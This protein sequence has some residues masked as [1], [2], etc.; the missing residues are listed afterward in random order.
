M[1]IIAVHA[2]RQTVWRFRQRYPGRVLCEVVKEVCEAG[3]DVGETLDGEVLRP[4]GGGERD[5]QVRHCQHRSEGGVDLELAGDRQHHGID[6]RATESPHQV[7]DRGA[8]RRRLE[9]SMPSMAKHTAESPVVAAS[10][11]PPSNKAGIT[12]NGIAMHIVQH[13]RRGGA[14]LYRFS[15]PRAIFSR[16]TQQPTDCMPKKKQSNTSPASASS[17]IGTTWRTVS[18]RSCTPSGS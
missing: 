16:Y 3:D 9:P 18:R 10:K 6:R 4:G 7:G 15:P 17:T 13:A 14:R 12:T 8:A 2:S 5:A 1:V 11:M